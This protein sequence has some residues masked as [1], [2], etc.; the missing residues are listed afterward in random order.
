MVRR[1]M[2]I[3]AGWLWLRLVVGLFRTRDAYVRLRLVRYIRDVTWF[4]RD[5]RRFRAMPSQ[6]FQLD[7]VFPCLSDRTT[8]TPVDPLYFYQDCWFA[9]KIFELK[10]AHH[11]DVGSSVRSIG[12]VSQFVPITMFDIRPI[13]LKLDQL[14]FRQGSIL[15]LPLADNSVASISSLCVIEHIGLGRYGD[16]LDPQGS[17]KAIAELKRVVKPGGV[18]MVS[19]PVDRVN[20]VYFNAHRAF[21]RDYFLQLFQGCTLLEEK[22]IY[23]SEMVDYYDP[24]RGFG[25][26]LYSFRKQ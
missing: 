5:F 7:R 8:F 24:G 2:Q 1:L 6:A 4:L 10:P 11:Y 20:R 17:E 26:G 9:R 23:G 12:L 18:I 14:E 21:T 19:V 22:Y 25:T 15:D 3:P 16:P 13:P